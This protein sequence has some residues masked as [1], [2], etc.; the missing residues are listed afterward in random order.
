MNIIQ[1]LR[2]RGFIHYDEEQGEYITDPDIEK[3]AESTKLKCYAGF[4]PTA[5]S[6]H[7]GNLLVIMALAQFQR[8]GHRPIALVGGA[9]GMIGDPSGK[10]KERQLLDPDQVRANMEGI[11][12]QLQ[13]FLDFG[14]TEDG[15]LLVNNGDWLLKFGFV[16]FL[17]EVGKHFRLPYMLNKKSVKLRQEGEGMSFTE[18]SYMLMQAYD[19]LHLFDSFGCEIQVGGSDQWGNITAG[20]D[21][22]WKLRQ[23]KACG[24]AFP[25]I[26]ASGGQKFG[27]SEGNAIWL[28]ANVTSPFDFYQFWIRTDDRDVIRFLKLFTFLAL[29][30]ISNI[31]AS[32]QRNPE[33]RGA[34]RT[35]AQEVTKLVH[36]EDTASKQHAVAALLFGDHT[37]GADAD[38]STIAELLSR[39]PSTDLSR[40]ELSRGMNV[41][42]VFV[43]SGLCRSNSE[44]RRL[45]SNGGAYINGDRVQNTA[46]TVGSESLIGNKVLVIRSGKRNYHLIS[47]G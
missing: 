36:G 33:A 8:H 31:D 10:S 29:D 40:T 32:L 30:E 43:R 22:I 5:S 14:D 2:A 38:A 20:N 16:D 46:M 21:L 18:F 39:V 4:D 26:E 12:K 25:L 1:T 41:V 17:R 19:F 28:D 24:I 23:R 7:V 9:T 34:Q 35:L 6:L 47:F 15:A 27:K 11:K 44:A 13:K 3:F 42:E 37:H 45:I